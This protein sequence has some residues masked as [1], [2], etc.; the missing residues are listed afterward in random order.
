MQ[1]IAATRLHKNFHRL[2]IF[3]EMIKRNVFDPTD[4]EY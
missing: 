2:K 1:N 4:A 3:F